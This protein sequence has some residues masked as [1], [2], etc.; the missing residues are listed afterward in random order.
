VKAISRK[1]GG[2][3]AV[4]TLAAACL[5]AGYLASRPETHGSLRVSNESY[6]FC[7]WP[8]TNAD[9]QDQAANGRG[10]GVDYL[11]L[12]SNEATVTVTSVVPIGPTGGI[13]VQSVAFVPGGEVGGGFSGTKGIVGTSAALV[14]L[15]RRV[16]ASLRFMPPPS[17]LD[18]S[19]R[20]IYDGK[21]WQ[22]AVTVSAPLSAA[23]ASLNGFA[24]TYKTGSV[25]RHLKTADTITIGRKKSVCQ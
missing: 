15:A 22:L 2:I 18:E 10:F 8:T 1:P 23:K 16:P 13:G 24:V 3:A 21:S 20:S 4:A 25:T 17:G 19:T 5:G 6:G 11:N 7:W 9:W 12:S 14:A